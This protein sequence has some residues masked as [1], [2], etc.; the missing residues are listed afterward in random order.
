MMPVKHALA[1]R[2]LITWGR[3]D[4]RV[5]GLKAA[6]ERLGDARLWRLQDFEGNCAATTIVAALQVCHPDRR[7]LIRRQ[8]G[9]ISSLHIPQR[10]TNGWSRVA[11]GFSSRVT[12]QGGG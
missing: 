6:T 1:S 2:A 10:N 5:S 12:V 3:K 9:F 4:K 8:T 11:G 7:L